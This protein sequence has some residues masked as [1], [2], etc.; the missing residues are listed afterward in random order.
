LAFLLLTL[1]PVAWAWPASAQSDHAPS[2]TVEAFVDRLTQEARQVPLDRLAAAGPAP[3]FDRPHPAIPVDTLTAEQATRLAA[4]LLKA[5]APS[6][7][8]AYLRYHLV[9]ALD[10][11]A[12][13][14]NAASLTSTQADQI[15]RAAASAL[16]ASPAVPFLS[17]DFDLRRYREPRDKFQRWTSLWDDV[18]L[19]VGVPPFT[20]RLTGEA[21]LR[22][23]TAQQAD[24]LRAAVRERDRLD[25]ELSDWVTDHDAVAR[26]DRRNQINELFR[27]TRI[28]AAELILRQGDGPDLVQLFEQACTQLDRGQA[29]GFDVLDATHRAIVRGS[30]DLTRLDPEHTRA[31][32]RRL[33]RSA[34]ASDRWLMPAEGDTRLDN[35]RTDLRNPARLAQSLAFYFE[36]PGLTASLARDAA[37]VRPAAR[38]TDRPARTS[39]P[40]LSLASIQ[41]AIEQ[42][43][44]R[45]TDPGA[46]D[47]PDHALG[48]DLPPWPYAFTIGRRDLRDTRRLAPGTHAALAWAQIATGQPMQAPG[49]QQRIH[50]AMGGDTLMSFNVAMRAILAA[51]LPRSIFEPVLR[52]EVDALLDGMSRQAGFAERLHENADWGDHAHAQ[53]AAYALDAADRAGLSVPSQ[54]WVGIDRHWRLT[55]Q[56]TPNDAPAGWRIDG[57]PPQHPDATGSPSVFATAG[58][59]AALTLTD[60]LLDTDRVPRRRAIDKGLAWLDQH[61]TAQRDDDAI[62]DWYFGMWSIQ[63]V[64]LATGR[65]R[66]NGIDWFRDITPLILRNQHDGLW[67]SAAFG[68]DPT[69]PTAMAMLY[70]ATALDPVAI[71]R[72]EHDAGW[73]DRLHALTHFTRTISDRYEHDTH[74]TTTPLDRP[75]QTLTEYPMLFLA[76]TEA[77][78]LTSA[79]IDTLR[80]YCHAGGLLILNP[81]D[82]SGAVGRSFRS[83]L[84]AL[85]PGRPTRT[86]EPD[87]PIYQVH[88]DVRPSIRMQAIGTDVR[89][90]AVWTLRDLGGPLAQGRGDSDALSTLSN[91]YLHRVGR[92]PRRT[93]LQSTYLPPQ[94]DTPRVVRAVRLQHDGDHDPEPAAIEQLARHLAA[95]HGLTL[96]HDTRDASALTDDTRIAFLTT[97]GNGSLTAEQAAAI[98]AWLQRGGTLILDAAG[99]SADA[100]AAAEAMLA[101]IA[102]DRPPSPIASGSP[103]VTGRGLADDP[104]DLSSVAYRLYTLQQG[105]MSDR[106]RLVTVA[107][108]GRDAIVF[109]AEDLTAGWAGVEH[110]G[111]NGY[112]IDDAR[113]LGA[114]LVLHAIAEP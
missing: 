67:T 8:S 47:S 29:F 74:W 68:D 59:V 94:P 98:R 62:I 85:A 27:S 97:P 6:S 18:G 87:D 14:P 105:V 31:V 111:I 36:V 76:A 51:Q 101:A 93:R 16:S 69:M 100:V 58:G 56:Q 41:H 7:P 13:R 11:F 64:G 45:I 83:L 17:G 26:N 61:F 43:R 108:E 9:G 48:I 99:G 112:A 22:A 10:A 28:S 42:A 103:I 4:E 33:H 82:P 89:P 72:V 50:A 49:V 114:N 60:R 77:I 19:E 20:R 96:Q 110:W 73:D 57:H 35:L 54:A 78:D 79:E 70:L 113:R 95:H 34:Q 63:Q 102:P 92:N 23:A 24:R 15:A 2:P 30:F 86:I 53:Y 90:W 66:F 65:A 40:E 38:P 46:L 106:P 75:L 84:Q 104:A 1:A 107:I 37:A 21:A 5:T 52:R 88:R 44:L 109:S 80:D 55:Q 39:R 25:R 71:A 91:L 81:S 32:A 3:T 12:T